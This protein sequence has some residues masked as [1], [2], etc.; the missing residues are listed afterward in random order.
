MPSL[1]ISQGKICSV[2]SAI[3]LFELK[4]VIPFSGAV[5]FVL[6]FTVPPWPY[7]LY[8]NSCNKIGYC[9]WRAGIELLLD[10]LVRNSAY[11]LSSTLTAWTCNQASNSILFNLFYRI[12]DSLGWLVSGWPWAYLR[13]RTL[14]CSTRTISF[15]FHSGQ[16]YIF[17]RLLSLSVFFFSFPGEKV[18]MRNWSTAMLACMFVQ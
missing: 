13:S 14:K 4:L 6:E 16:R 18:S 2:H 17:V 15:P 3:K 5:K 10:P 1:V 7:I 11:Y 12:C 8:Y 9:Y